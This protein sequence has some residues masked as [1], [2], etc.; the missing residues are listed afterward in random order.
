LKYPD[1]DK[2]KKIEGVVYLHFMIDRLGK[3]NDIKV[4]KGVSR[5]CDAEAIRLVQGM[6]KWKPG[7][8]GGRPVN[9]NYSLPV[10]FRLEENKSAG[11]ER[12]K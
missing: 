4:L 6:P 3:I 9:V 8:Q 11:K 5:L 1:E 2:K 10:R 12:K 7:K